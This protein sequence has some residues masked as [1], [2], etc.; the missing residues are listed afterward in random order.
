[1]SY[2][3]SRRYD[4]TVRNRRSQPFFTGLLELLTQNLLRSGAVSKEMVITITMC[5]ASFLCQG[6]ANVA[7][8]N[9]RKLSLGIPAIVV[10]DSGTCKSLLLEIFMGPILN[11]LKTWLKKD[12]E[13]L[14]SDLFTEDAS[15]KAILEHLSD[16]PILGLFADEGSLIEELVKNSSALLAKLVRSEPFRAARHG[17]KRIELLDYKFCMMLEMQPTAFKSMK[18]W[19]GLEPGGIGLGNRFYI[20]FAPPNMSTASRNEVCLSDDVG[21]AYAKTACELAETSMRNAETGFETIP[22]IHL[23]DAAKECLLQLEH[24]TLKSRLPGQP[25]SHLAEYQ[26]RHVERVL[27]S[28]GVMHVFEH[29]PVGEIS[30]DTLQ[31]AVM[32]GEWYVSSFERGTYVPPAPPKRS[33][34]EIDAEDLDRALLQLV[35]TRGFTCFEQSVIRAYAFNLGLTPSRFTRALALLGKQGNVYVYLMRNKPIIQ[36]NVPPLAQ[37]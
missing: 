36:V 16:F 35:K 5:F 4:I 8:V 9:G 21:A 13:P 34:Q 18:R 17:S 1:M 24:D 22:T 3:D 26:T 19:L 12:G 2:L 33:Q 6:V 11:W 15:R 32:L 7:W 28:A 25:W 20:A 30:L 14:E 31:R 37:Y 29:G 23:C 10:S 27:R